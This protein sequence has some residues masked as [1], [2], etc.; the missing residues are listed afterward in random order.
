MSSPEKKRKHTLMA[1]IQVLSSF[2]IILPAQFPNIVSKAKL[3]VQEKT[4][5][6]R[7]KN[8]NGGVGE[9][10]RLVTHTY[11]CWSE[12]TEKRYQKYQCKFNI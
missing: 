12:V 5:Q 6:M 2:S 9:W 4:K 8:R 10:K 11:R 3:P 7:G 1:L